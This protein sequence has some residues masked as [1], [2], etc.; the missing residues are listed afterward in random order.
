MTTDLLASALER[1]A[2]LDVEQSPGTSFHYPGL[3]FAVG[4]TLD[5]EVDVDD[6]EVRG[7]GHSGAEKRKRR[8]S[9]PV[10][11]PVADP[12]LVAGEEVPSEEEEE[13]DGEDMVMD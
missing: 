11:P 8:A 5:N 3:P 9:P 2:F 4:Y 12:A 13:E 10:V 6:G 7:F 1:H